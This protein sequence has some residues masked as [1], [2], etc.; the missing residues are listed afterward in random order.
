MSSTTIE[1]SE[2]SDNNQNNDMADILFE[3]D[4]SKPSNIDKESL[5]SKAATRDYDYLLGMKLWSLT[6]ER[7]TQ[8]NDQLSISEIQ[9]AEL[10]NKSEAQLWVEDLNKAEAMIKEYYRMRE[11]EFNEVMR[12]RKHKKRMEMPS[13][14]P[15]LSATILVSLQKE[16][17]KLEKKAAI[18]GKQQ[19]RG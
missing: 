4:L 15:P 14:I 6:A 11:R 19:T 1:L 16:Q 10:K 12:K 17:A 2:E 3:N 9:L 13:R 8:L 18:A 7:I 5:E